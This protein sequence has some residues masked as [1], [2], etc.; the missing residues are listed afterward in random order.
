MNQAQLWV[1]CL[2]LKKSLNLKKIKIMHKIVFYFIFIISLSSLNLMGL[3]R[4]LPKKKEVSCFNLDLFNEEISKY[5]I[6]QINFI[7]NSALRGKLVL[8]YLENKKKRTN[9]ILYKDRELFF[10]QFSKGIINLNIQS[11]LDVVFDYISYEFSELQSGEYMLNFIF[12]NIN[13][14]GY[15]FD[16]I[17]DIE[18]NPLIN[19]KLINFDSAFVIGKPS[20]FYIIANSLQEFYFNNICNT[21][22]ILNIEEIFNIEDLSD[23]HCFSYKGFNRYGLDCVIIIEK[24]DIRKHRMYNSPLISLGKSNFILKNKTIMF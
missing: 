16:C 21:D 14:D 22:F 11:D 2:Q 5:K 7:N 15:F 9:R 20:S 6:T 23:D 12:K 8:N 10:E 24:N 13:K 17:L 19:F 18:F 3:K 4:F 1:H